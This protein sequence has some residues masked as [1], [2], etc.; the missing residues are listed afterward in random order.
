[1]TPVDITVLISTNCVRQKVNAQVNATCAVLFA[2][3]RVGGVV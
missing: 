2:S 3:V 1:V